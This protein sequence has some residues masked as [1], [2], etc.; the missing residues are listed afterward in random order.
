MLIEL[1]KDFREESDRYK[2]TSIV[3]ITFSL[4]IDLIFFIVVN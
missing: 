4:I 2:K 1:F 3:T